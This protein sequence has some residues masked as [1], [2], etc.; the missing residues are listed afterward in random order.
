MERLSTL[1]V[2]C[3]SPANGIENAKA[4]LPFANCA[5]TISAVL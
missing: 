2:S 1:C 5:I 3:G 4:A